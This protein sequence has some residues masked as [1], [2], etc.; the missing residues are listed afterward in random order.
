M[1]SESPVNSPA[2]RRSQRDR[3]ATKPFAPVVSQSSKGKRKR[4]RKR[5]RHDSDAEGDETEEQDR[6]HNDALPQD[7]EDD[8]EEEGEDYRAPK[9]KTPAKKKAQSKT[10]TPKVK[11]PPP[12][13]KPR[14]AKAAGEKVTKPPTS[15][16]GRKPKEGDDAYDAAQVAKDTKITADN[17]LFNAV[18]NPS[19]ALQSTAED[20]LE[21]LEQSSDAALAE[22]INLILRACGCNDSVNSDEAIDYDGV[23]D[24]LDNFTEGLKQVRLH[25]SKPYFLLMCIHR[26]IPQYTL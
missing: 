1:A 8:A 16:R 13:K 12:V 9:P 6:E 10:A 24:A 22:L 15:K 4:K 7:D 21:S 17:P 11:G 25:S 20:F 3:K 23:V 19:A 5:K 26:T 14:I 18:M 2:P